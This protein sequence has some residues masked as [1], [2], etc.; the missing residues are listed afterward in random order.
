MAET[1]REVDVKQMTDHLQS[2]DGCKLMFD[3]AFSSMNRDLDGQMKVLK[4]IETEA[5]Q[6]D[7]NKL[8]FVPIDVIA[9]SPGN[10]KLV[11]QKGL[12]IK[13]EDK[14]IFSEV[15]VTEHENKRFIGIQRACKFKE[16]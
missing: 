15:G 2:G 13:R 3:E 11:E 14:P 16:K 5:Q 4:Q 7:E 1:T 10:G 12:E 9:R 8:T 6:R